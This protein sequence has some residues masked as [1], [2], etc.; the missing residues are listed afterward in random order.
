[1][2]RLRGS[3][4][5]IRP[6]KSAT[7][8]FA[9][10]NRAQRRFGGLDRGSR[11]PAVCAADSGMASSSAD[12]SPDPYDVYEEDKDVDDEAEDDDDFDDDDDDDDD[13]A[14]EYAP[15]LSPRKKR[16]LLQRHTEEM[17]GEITEAPLGLGVPRLAKPED[18]WWDGADGAEV[19]GE[20][21]GGGEGGGEG[22]VE[23]DGDEV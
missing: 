14:F 1:M 16:R 19:R 3:A 22:G 15:Q 10:Q 20:V 7:S 12:V 17:T 8:A 11:S 21:K 13:E 2:S 18:L 9:S 23:G 6:R 5:S 4:P